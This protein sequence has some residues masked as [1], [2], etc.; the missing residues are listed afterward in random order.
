MEWL[1]DIFFKDLGEFLRHKSNLVYVFLFFYLFEIRFL[2]GKEKIIEEFKSAIDEDKINN[3]NEQTNNLIT[4]HKGFFSVK[5]FYL[6]HAIVSFI[7]TLLVIFLLWNGI[8][9]FTT[10]F[11]I[12]NKCF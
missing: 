2:I 7:F 5:S 9:Y 1:S 10:S 4:K 11:C 12:G 6:P 8:I 3:S